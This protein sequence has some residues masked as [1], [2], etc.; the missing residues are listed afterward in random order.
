LS[1]AHYYIS[2]SVKNKSAKP[3]VIGNVKKW[4]S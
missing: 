4:L 2:R 1:D 3:V